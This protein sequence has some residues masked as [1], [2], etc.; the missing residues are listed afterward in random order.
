[1]AFMITED[2][3][4]CDACVPECPNEAIS[5]GDSIYVIDAA[6]CTECVPV[7]DQQQCAVVCPVDCCIADPNQVE[8]KEQLEAKYSTLH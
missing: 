4:N 8:N 1:M 2:C 3:I 6:R 7:H 5:Q